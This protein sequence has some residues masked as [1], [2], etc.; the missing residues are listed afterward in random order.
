MP[1][2]V[3]TNGTKVCRYFSALY[4]IARVYA[5]IS[6]GFDFVSLRSSAIALILL[7]FILLVS[8]CHPYKK[9]LYNKMDVFFFVII[10]GA[11]IFGS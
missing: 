3:V 6:L 2:K 1:L 9:M 8:F 4:L 7:K 11:I 5:F 10:I